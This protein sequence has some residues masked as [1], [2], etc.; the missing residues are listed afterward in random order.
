MGFPA[1]VPGFSVLLGAYGKLFRDPWAT[2]AAWDAEQTITAVIPALNEERTIAHA[3]ASLDEQTVTPNELIVIDDGSTDDTTAVVDEIA[4]A[5]AFPIQ[6]VQHEEPM[7]K[8]PSIKQV[9]RESTADLLFVLDADTY[10]ESES[11]L[12]QVREPHADSDVACTFGRVGPITRSHRRSF[13]QNVVSERISEESHTEASINANTDRGLTTSLQYWLTRWPIEQYRALL[14]DIEQGFTKDA[15]MRLYETALFP[16]GCGV[17][18]NRAVLVDVFDQY[19]SSLGDNLTNSED[20]FLGY[21]F[22]DKGLSN[23][24]IPDVKMRTTEPTVRNFTSQLYLWGSANLQ[25]AYYF[26]D[27]LVRIRTRQSTEATEQSPPPVGRAILAQ[28]VDGLYPVGLIVLAALV[29]LHLAS[30]EWL[31]LLVMVEYALYTV[32]AVVCSRQRGTS[33]WRSLFA[34]PIR[35]LALPI[36][37]YTYARVGSDIIRGNRDWRK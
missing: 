36:T 2:A 10:L 11:Y 21:A 16:A 7:G 34:A 25:S 18:Y 35:F 29:V 32:I 4:E 24:Q 37:A 17:L 3:I 19:E 6:V 8:T 33:L 9:A 5:V 14:Y 12:E 28:L 13:T 26:R 23:V 22:V 15:S 27:S 31:V 30:L 20:I 1:P